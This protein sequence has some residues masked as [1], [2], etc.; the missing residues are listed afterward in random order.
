M[1]I[2]SYAGVTDFCT[3]DI[4]IWT[5]LLLISCGCLFLA[6][7]P[8]WYYIAAVPDS[9]V[10][11]AFF[12][13]SAVTLMLLA[14]LGA[15]GALKKHKGVLLYFALVMVVMMSFTIAQ[16]SLTLIALTSCGPGSSG[17]FNFMC[18]INQAVFFAHST[19]IIVVAMMCCLCSWC[20]RWRLQKQ[21]DDPNNKY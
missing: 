14:C 7:G 18:E 21:E 16:V 2:N 1:A 9:A 3:C 11:V 8:Y 6:T 20:L 5:I 4:L 19:I 10:N 12:T 15:Y 13:I 17:F